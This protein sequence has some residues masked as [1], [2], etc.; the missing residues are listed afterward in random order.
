[1][2]LAITSTWGP[3]DPTRAALPFAFADSALKADDTV[4][5][6]LLH[7]AVT[8]AVLGEA[9]KIIPS[10][11]PAKFEDIFSH[12]NAQ[13]IVCRSCAEVRGITKEML[14]RNCDLGGMNDLHA[15]ISR[16]DCKVVN[17]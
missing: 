11:P 7:D 5:I 13:I 17:F 16:A 6:M 9:Q 2:H 3:A 8:I 15:H 10:G 12:R 14:E 1:M 4:M